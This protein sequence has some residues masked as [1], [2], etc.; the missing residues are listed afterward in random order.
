MI[1]K[2]MMID[3]VR[4]LFVKISLIELPKR[5][6]YGCHPALPFYSNRPAD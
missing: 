5:E 2:I 6:A 3:S 1:I 4:W